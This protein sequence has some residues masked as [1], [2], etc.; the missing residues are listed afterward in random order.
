MRCVCEVEWA[1][2]PLLWAEIG[3]DAAARER[4]GPLS[5]FSPCSRL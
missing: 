5:T 1:D 2:W 3:H 4:G